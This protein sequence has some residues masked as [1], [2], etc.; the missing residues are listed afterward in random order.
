MASQDFNKSYQKPE[1]SE[2]KIAE[3]AEEISSNQTQNFS[4]IDALV[5]EVRQTVYPYIFNQ[6]GK[7]RL[8][9]LYEQIDLHDIYTDVN[10]LEQIS[11]RRRLEIADLHKV[12][13]A[14]EF[15][16]PGLGGIG[17]QRMTG[18]AAVKQYSNLIVLGKPGSGKT[19]F[20][21]H[22]AIQ[23]ISGN[24]QSHL[25]PIFITLK[26]FA[27]SKNCS[28]LI[29]YINQ[30]LNACNVLDDSITEELLNH[31]KVLVL[32]DG[33]DEV[34]E[35]DE[36]KTLK[37]LSKIYTKFSANKFI[38]TCRIAAKQ[39]T[40]KNFTE[41]EVADFNDEQIISFA[42]KWFSTR[43]T[44]QGKN[45]VDKLKN[46]FSIK[47][48]A[49]NPL[50]LTLLCLTFEE[51]ADFPVNRLELYKEGINL[52]LKKWDAVR[53]IE[54]DRV[55]KKL[56]VQYKQNLLSKI[57]LT[58]FERGDYFFKQQELEQYIIDYIINLHDASTEFEVLHLDAN[59][60]LRSIEAQHGLLVERARGIYSFSHLTFHEYFTAQEI[61]T[62]GE[63][64]ALEIA[65]RQLVSRIAEKRWREVF[66]LTLG[67]LRNADYL[68]QLMKQQIDNLI[69][70]DQDL[71]N[72]LIWVS[73]KSFAVDVTYKLTSVRAFYLELHL[74]IDLK[75]Y[76]S[77]SL[78]LKLDPA[79]GVALKR[80][81]ELDYELN[82]ALSLAG[83]LDSSL[84]PSLSLTLD[85][86]ISLSLDREL[87]RLLQNLKD[88]LPN[89]TQSEGS[90]RKWWKV[91]GRAWTEQL[92]TLQIKYRNIGYD[93]QFNTQQRQAL[94][95]YYDANKLLWD[96][97]NS[98]CYMTHAVR[99]EIEETMLLPLTEIQ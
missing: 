85:H 32:L 40:L 75:I 84:A 20:L 94:Q 6:C 66:L 74:D 15:E 72:F 93:W 83:K 65:L 23:C 52:L 26:N 96:C 58:T 2:E 77:L 82:F 50:L 57:A 11:S 87:Q 31:G 42:R 47:E 51:S 97:I 39:Y 17:E 48:L 13:V 92:R 9:G 89:L 41:V 91:N 8:L 33:L 37:Q 45:F 62:N 14:D 79:L 61:V 99:Q 90:F 64:Q 71:Q 12:S 69:A 38:V 67:M 44:I 30:K 36:A 16:R 1:V 56:S 49:T 7:M 5:Q 19:T 63:P 68:I 29:E 98:S 24:F 78:A 70:E 53:N 54:R 18:L 76:P 4:D 59:A 81:L 10:I 25:V 3:M 55:Y 80:D 27:E 88:R 35:A 34:M 21:K 22:I 46:N 86:A 60:V 73:R 95:Q 28:S 43:D